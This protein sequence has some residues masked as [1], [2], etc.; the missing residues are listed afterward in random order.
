[1]KFMILV[2][3]SQNSEAGV[4]PDQSLLVAM[5]QYNEALVNAGVMKAG[6]G[7]HPTSNSARV[8][9]DGDSRAVTEGPFPLTPDTLAGFWIWE[10]A[11]KQEAIDWVKKCPNPMPGEVSEIE[12]RQIFSVEDFCDAATPEI[13]EH[14][15]R[16]RARSEGA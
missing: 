5:G 7:L 13:R 3:A 10:V 6:E 15:A 11:S 4:M 2:K 9:F 8:R 16:L 12:I 1:M 14:E